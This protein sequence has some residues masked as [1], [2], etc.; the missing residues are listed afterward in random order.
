MEDSSH[1]LDMSRKVAHPIQQNLYPEESPPTH[2]HAQTPPPSPPGASPPP[3]TKI[4]KK[5]PSSPREFFA[6]LYGPDTDQDTS[7]KSPN[8]PQDILKTTL[9]FPPYVPSLDFNPYLP[10]FPLPPHQAE[11]ISFE[12]LPFPAGLAAFCKYRLY[13]ILI[14]TKYYGQT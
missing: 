8:P 7:R 4:V 3:L 10:T 13:K 2:P 5:A 1:P 11:M 9:D 6:K 14:I 12:T